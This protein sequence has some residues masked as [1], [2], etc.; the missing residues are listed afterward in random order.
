MKRAL[1]SRRTS[2]GIPVSWRAAEYAALKANAEDDCD[3]RVSEEIF[4]VE[5]ERAAVELIVHE[6]NHR[7]N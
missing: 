6:L 1:T 5:D 7:V 2:T 3:D 4:D